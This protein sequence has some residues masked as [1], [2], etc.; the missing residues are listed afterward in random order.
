MTLHEE[1]NAQCKRI[2]EGLFHTH[3]N[4]HLA[5]T[6]ADTAYLANTL[7][8][9]MRD[10]FEVISRASPKERTPETAPSESNKNR[11]AGEGARVQL[12][13]DWTS[14]C[15]S[16]LEE[17]ALRFE[18]QNNR[19]RDRDYLRDVMNIEPPFRVPSTGRSSAA[20]TP[21]HP[22]VNSELGHG[23]GQEPAS[24][25]ERV[26][27]IS[28][29][30]IDVTRSPQ[31][32]S[33]IQPETPS[34]SFRA[35]QH[36]SDS[37]TKPHLCSGSE[38]LLP[39]PNWAR[40]HGKRRKV[41]TPTGFSMDAVIF[42]S[43]SSTEGDG[44]FVDANNALGWLKRYEDAIIATIRSE[45]IVETQGGSKRSRAGKRRMR[46][47]SRV[48]PLVHLTRNALTL[49][50]DDIFRSLRASEASINTQGGQCQDSPSLSSSRLK[51]SV[52][53]RAHLSESHE[54]LRPQSRTW[55]VR[56]LTE[57]ISVDTLLEGTRAYMDAW[58]GISRGGKMLKKQVFDEVRSE[59]RKR[60][61]EM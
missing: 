26:N 35:A 4:T 59:L 24:P 40:G 49:A 8:M 37:Q 31:D 58:T 29:V 2:A 1:W 56:D 21:C 47:F 39:L 9:S 22:R 14:L 18:P 51:S 15:D 27:D 5:H 48:E 3:P 54:Y 60:R 13:R 23:H 44:I 55:A 53:A 6:E 41:H 38:E 17:A 30:D 46:T 16:T 20:D 57:L 12:H 33:Q 45:Y 19:D 28:H 11:N 7:S 36:L 34:I 32:V 42:S 10:P 43:D 52:S 25:A 61:R 50:A